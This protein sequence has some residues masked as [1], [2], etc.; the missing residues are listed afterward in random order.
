MGAGR[1]HVVQEGETLISLAQ[2]YYGNREQSLQLYHANRDL[3]MA[4]DRLPV[5]AV[6]RIPDLPV[7]AD[8]ER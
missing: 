8:R 1:S 5:G 6:L 4:P 2:H 3:L 7:C